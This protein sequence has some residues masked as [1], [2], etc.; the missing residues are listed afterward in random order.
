MLIKDQKIEKF[1]EEVASSAP[2]PGGGAVAAVTGALAASLVEMVWNLTKTEDHQR[3]ASIGMARALKLKL[4]ELADKDVEA[5]DLVMAGYRSK[6]NS[7]I[8]DALKKAIEV[9][10]KTKR[11]SHL[12]EEL[13]Q[14]V[15][16]IGNKNAVSDAK[17]AIYLAQAAQNSAQENIE[18]NKKF[19]AKLK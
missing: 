13:A 19:L 4:L 14:T 3:A 1:L 11:L 2:T 16:K 15:A 7:K 12:I 17:T 18:I 8:K 9:P 5:F 10:S 6:N